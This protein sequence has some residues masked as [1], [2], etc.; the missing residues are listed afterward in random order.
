MVEKI[1]ADYG[2]AYG[3]RHV[4]L[5]YFNA[6]GAD[7]TARSASGT[8]PKPHVIP[9]AI[10]AAMA[11]EDSFRIFGDDFD[12]RD[13]TAIRDYIHVADLADAHVRAL[14]YLQGGGVSDVFNLGTG[15]GTSVAEIAAAVER[16]GV[17][18]C[19]GW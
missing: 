15:V 13:G 5:R 6:A 11:G 2:A 3:L 9:L 4:A 16:V 8:C 19:S 14:D 10:R 12:T 18:R 17:G 1:L 7:L